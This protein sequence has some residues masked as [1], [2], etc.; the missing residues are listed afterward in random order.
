MAKYKCWDPG[1]LTPSPPDG[2]RRPLPGPSW[3]DFRGIF[4]H[5]APPC[6]LW[7]HLSGGTRSCLAHP[8]Q[9]RP[10]LDLTCSPAGDKE[11]VTR[12]EPG[13][14]WWRARNAGPGSGLTVGLELLMAESSWL[15]TEEPWGW[16]A[17][18]E[19]DAWVAVH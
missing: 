13:G 18:A 14:G 17:A 15:E 1:G 7:T 19:P 3:L 6:P 12:N 11:G 5:A 2:R 9:L 16:V 10:E 8:A 4:R